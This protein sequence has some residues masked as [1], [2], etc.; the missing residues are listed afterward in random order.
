M[1][2]A[3]CKTVPQPL[4]AL[5]GPQFAGDVAEV[6]I[7][8]NGIRVRPTPSAPRSAPLPHAIQT[9][10]SVWDAAIV[11]ARYLERLTKEN[12]FAARLQ[13]PRAL[14][15]GS[16]A[17]V[18]GI[19]TCAALRIPTVLTDVPQVLPCLQQT[20]DSLEGSLGDLISV[21]ACDWQKGAEDV[22]ALGAPFGLIVISDCFWLEHLVDDL[23][24]VL[25]TIVEHHR[26]CDAN[27]GEGGVA[28]RVLVAHQSRSRRLD[29][30]VFSTLSRSFRVSAAEMLAGEPDRGKVDLYWAISKPD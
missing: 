6:G 3:T 23:I 30:K 22:A 29:E 7:E 8:I 15:L 2:R 27:K 18:A 17:G 12:D 16:G 24:C 9:A 25:E 19:A 4:L 14:E 21:K 20:V 5:P 10:F 26:G 1:G 13:P 28:T 11:V